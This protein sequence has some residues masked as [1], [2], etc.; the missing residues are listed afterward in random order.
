VPGLSFSSC[1]AALEVSFP[2]ST[3]FSSSASINR[4]YKSYVTY[5]P[6]GRLVQ[7][8]IAARLAA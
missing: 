2:D 8:A 4:T 1:P 6:R 7:F 5:R 3:S